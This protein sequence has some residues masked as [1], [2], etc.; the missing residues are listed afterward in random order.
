[1]VMETN[2]TELFKVLGPEFKNSE[3]P[4]GEFTNQSLHIRQL[5]ALNPDTLGM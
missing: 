1:M 2:Q 5:P 3:K 4:E